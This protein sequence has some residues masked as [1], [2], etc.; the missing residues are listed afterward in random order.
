MDAPDSACVFCDRSRTSARLITANSDWYVV[1]TLGQ[2]VGGYVLVIPKEHVSCLGALTSGQAESLQ[3]MVGKVSHALFREYPP[4]EPTAPYSVTMF[5]HG[6]VGQTVK[7]AH[8]HILPVVVDLTKKIRADFPSVVI[9]ELPD[10]TY[11]QELYS[12]C[13]EPYLFWTSPDGRSMLCRNTP[14]PPQYLRLL[15]AELLGFPERGVWHDGD[16]A[17]SLVAQETVARLQPYFL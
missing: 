8:L 12:N 16:K 14:A 5:E 11:L 6:V 17:D 4:R 10:S 7:H 2:I 9:E 13:S 1:A 3:V 15:V